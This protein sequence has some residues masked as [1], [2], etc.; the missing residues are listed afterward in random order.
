[1]TT[2][3][4]QKSN[5]NTFVDESLP[6]WDLTDFYD[7]IKDPKIQEDLAH[8]MSLAKNF[9]QSYEKKFTPNG[10]LTGSWKGEDLY[11]ALQEYEN[12]D[13][14]LGKLISYGYLSFATNVNNPPVL[15]F[16]QMIQEQ[17]TNISS[18]LIFFTLELNQIEDEALKKAY[19]DSADL[20]K[21]SPW[22][23]NIRLF[24]P[25]QLSADLEKLLHEKSVTGRSAWIRLFEETLAGMKFSLMNKEMTLA[26][27]LNLLSN[28]DAGARQSAAQALSEGLTRNASILTLV[29]NTLAK[30]KEIEDNWRQ[31]PHPVAARNLSNQVEDEVIEAL[32]SA[33][34]GSYSRLSHR[35]YALKAKWLGLKKLEYWDR[36]AP[37][38]EAEDNLIPWKDA[39]DIVLNAYQNFHPEMAQIGRKFFDQP[40]IDAPSQSGKESGA[41]SHPTVP[42]VHPYIL[43][44]YHGKLR[45]VM[46]LAH[47]LGHGIHQV[48]AAKQGFLLSATP[49]T[50][51][52]TASV[53]G[54]MLTF[55]ALLAKTTTPL[56][57]RSLLASKVDDMINT[58]VRQIAFFEFERTLHQKRRTGELTTDDIGAIWIETQKEALGDA[59]NLDPLVRPYWGYIS[60]FIHAPFY[61]YAYAFGD[62]LVN[63]LYS[64]YES[65]YPNFSNL[66]IDLLK[67]G[68]TKRYGELLE[69]FG[70]NAK[71][72]AF[73]QKGL[74]VISAL[75]D[76]LEQL[77]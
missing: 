31:Y 29:T 53:F 6:R 64:V 76:E 33:V 20:T 26:E 65:Q 77:S 69:P 4:T 13:E 52:E 24:R 8:A 45:D 49:L 56:Q 28:K 11:K 75:I 50:I 27:V 43:L 40:W 35:Y 42:N 16:F 68:G 72:P 58:V 22:V 39:Q 62:C 12:I 2:S 37:L 63:S 34:K 10:S 3:Q 9:C 38:P 18:N 47:E 70:L 25:H 66:Y 55:K 19:Q 30:D 71:D 59:V 1:M 54:E 74:N 61:V 51:A 15:Q 14:L 36:N 46:T 60:H 32:A 17:V 73:W 57:K 21:Y 48:L 23:D 44:N 67:A 5:Q 41:F 7:S